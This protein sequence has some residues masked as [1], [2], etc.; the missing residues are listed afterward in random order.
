MMVIG[1][2]RTDQYRGGTSL[3]TVHTGMIHVHVFL[4][5]SDSTLTLRK[6]SFGEQCRSKMVSGYV[7]VHVKRVASVTLA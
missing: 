3:V 7:H 2:S 6:A 5:E 4:H 1:S